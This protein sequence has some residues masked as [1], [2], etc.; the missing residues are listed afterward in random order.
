[1]D[2]SAQSIGV[3]PTEHGKGYGKK[4]LQLLC[5]T[6]DSLHASAYLET[7]SKANESMYQHFGFD[8]VEELILSAPKDN[9]PTAKFT[10][11]LMV[12]KQVGSTPE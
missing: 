10:M 12:R 8:T 1:M 4:M 7:C 3:R 6:A 5:K 9:S 2:L 11:Y